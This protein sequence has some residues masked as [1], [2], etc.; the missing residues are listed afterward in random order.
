MDF[1]E[2]AA[3][4]LATV[5]RSVAFSGQDGAFF[6][7][8]KADVIVELTAGILGHPS[9]LAALDVGCGVG[10][11]TGLVAPAFRAISGSDVSAKSLALAAEQVPSAE[12]RAGSGTALPFADD[13]FDVVYAVCVFH[14]VE[15][16][17]REALAREM[18]RVARPG[19]LVMILEHNPWNPLARWVVSRCPLDRDA[20]LL[21]AGVAETLLRRASLRPVARRYVALLP[22][23]AGWA[24]GV[25]RTLAGL[26][27]G[28]QYAVA[29][30]K[31]KPA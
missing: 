23:G 2:H 15:M 12:F 31:G 10:L 21:S 16:G 9:E 13:S 22:L 27:L 25:E 5:R 17:D 8:V 19:G 26:P 14:H 4:Y 20:R 29:A 7:Q 24:R 28:A 11:L 6:A 3:D 30:V 1:D 18:A